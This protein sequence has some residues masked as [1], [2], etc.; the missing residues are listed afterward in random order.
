MEKL[1]NKERPALL[2]EML[3]WFAE[4]SR[5]LLLII[6]SNKRISYINTSFK[7]A[8]QYDLSEIKG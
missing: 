8:V 2:T 3:G 4:T 6:D 5:D 7:K 1:Q